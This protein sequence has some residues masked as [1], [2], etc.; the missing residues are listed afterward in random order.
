M[1]SAIEVPVLMEKI[2]ESLHYNMI[3]F[4]EDSSHLDWSV[5]ELQLLRSRSLAYRIPIKLHL[6]VGLFK[7]SI[8]HV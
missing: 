6:Q 5:K 7:F 3:R 2:P 8:I 4:S 1:L